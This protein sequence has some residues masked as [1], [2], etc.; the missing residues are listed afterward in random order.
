MGLDLCS[1]EMGGYDSDG[2]YCEDRVFSKGY[3]SARSNSRDS[4][5]CKIITGHSLYEDFI[6]PE[7]VKKM[8]KKIAAVVNTAIMFRKKSKEWFEEFDIPEHRQER[9]KMKKKWGMYFERDDDT[10]EYDFSY[11]VDIVSPFYDFYD[12]CYWNLFNFIKDCA[13]NG[14]G[15]RSCY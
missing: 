2:E 1:A 13:E 12:G 9:Y 14:Y 11:Q 7:T 6:D 8:Y 5:A 10:G 15:I 4:D 3:K